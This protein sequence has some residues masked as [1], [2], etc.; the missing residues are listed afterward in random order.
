MNKKFALSLGLFLTAIT[1]CFGIEIPRPE[2]PRPQFERADWMNLNGTWSYEFDF[3]KSGI[4]RSLFTNEGF[5]KTILVPFCPES[6]LSGVN[7]KDFIDAM[8]YQRKLSIPEAWAG[9]RILLN[10]GG[11]DYKSTIYIN[12]QQAFVHYGGS[13]SFSVDITSYVTPGSTDNLVVYVEDDLRSGLQTSGKQS[14][15]LH[16]YSCLYTR[17]TGIWQTVW[18]EAVSKGGL[19]SCSIT[20]DLDNKQFVFEPVFYDLDQESSLKIRILDNG[21]EVFSQTTPAGNS[22]FIIGKLKNIK[23]WSPESPFLY[24][25]EFSVL[26]SKGQTIDK[27]NS[28]AGMRKAELR[29][30]TFYLNNKPY[31][32]RLVLDQGYYP[33][34]QWTA[35]DDT[36]LR[37]DIELGKEAGF[38]G[39]RLHQK[40][41]EPRYFYWADK[42]GYLTWG[43]SASW[44][45]NWTDPVAA[46]NMISEWEECIHR[47]YNAP[48][49]IAWS[50]LNETWMEDVDGQR[51]RLT[52]DLYFMTKRIDRTRPV[53]T[54]SGGYHAGFT[55]IYA[56][57]TYVQDPVLLYNQLAPNEEGYPY[58]FRPDQSAPYK[59]EAYMVDEFGG[60]QWIKEMKL[61]E[62]NDQKEF[63]GYGEPPKTLEEF[64]KRLEEQVNVILSLD[65]ITGFCYT[66]IV[67]VELEKNGIYTYDR[68]KKFDRSRIYKIFTKSRE[69]AKKEVK[70]MLSERDIPKEKSK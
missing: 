41:F 52:N 55:D 2:Y 50:P 70:E 35:P 30:K 6:P 14:H 69:Q 10:F 12:G 7:H 67:D 33:D 22:S 17:V 36:Q 46:R 38:N 65:H 24:D 29:G 49:L 1:T 5:G 20:P 18:L 45:V 42:L 59:G 19:K 57:H 54:V 51:A 43:E 66:Q 32:Q 34:G 31:Y 44:G 64:Y 68:N 37:R 15:R 25:I 26:N 23:T 58:V 21:K 4:E 62:V 13:S 63:W 27:V 11:V 3:S 9:K 48:S 40:V 60:I 28:Y 61:P 47:D 39:A 8:W 16:S 53:I 56:E